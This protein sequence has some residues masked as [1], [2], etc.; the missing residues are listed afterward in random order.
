M[1]W[2]EAYEYPDE[3]DEVVD[4]LRLML[5]LAAA[6]STAWDCRRGLF[7]YDDDMLQEAV[8]PSPG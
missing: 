6:R 1:L 8:S 4:G 5:E 3:A 2:S 7:R